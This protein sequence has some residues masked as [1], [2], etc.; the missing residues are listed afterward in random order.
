MEIDNR[1]VKA[2]N[3]KKQENKLTLLE[4]SESTGLNI[5]TLRTVLNGS[6]KNVQ[7]K[8]IKK[9]NAWIYQFV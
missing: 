6:N 1:L 9:L 7:Y 5:V 4:L 8:T 2:V 3:R